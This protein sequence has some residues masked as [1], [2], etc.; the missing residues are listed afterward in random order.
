MQSNNFISVQDSED[1]MSFEEFAES[2]ERILK[3]KVVGLFCG[4]CDWPFLFADLLQEF[5]L[6]FAQYVREKVE[7][8]VHELA[9]VLGIEATA[10]STERLK[11]IF[12]RFPR[13]VREVSRKEV[14][15]MRGLL[16]Q[17]IGTTVADYNASLHKDTAPELRFP[18]RDSQKL[19][20]RLEE[21]LGK[22]EAE[23]VFKAVHEQMVCLE[24]SEE[25]F[26]FPFRRKAD[27]L[28]LV[29]KYSKNIMTCVEGFI[30]RNVRSHSL[31]RRTVSCCC[32]SSPRRTPESC[33]ASESSAS[34][35]PKA[36][37]AS[38]STETAASSSLRRCR[39]SPR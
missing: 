14:E 35:C 12:R 2:F 16:R 28:Y 13:K 29:Q 31:T 1:L 34:R 37:S 4:F 39:C 27:R 10:E 32:R 30:A 21:G 38:A 17:L 5:Y 19:L 25:G 11:E 33:R 24:L 3:G 18:Q 20:Q 6:F 15:K 8:K 23:A 9:E 22:L 26:G 36:C 7:Y